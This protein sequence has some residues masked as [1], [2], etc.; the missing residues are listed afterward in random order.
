[1]GCGTAAFIQS[2]WLAAMRVVC[3]CV[4]VAYVPDRHWLTPSWMHDF[5]CTDKYAVLVEQPLYM[6]SCCVR[7]A[8]HTCG[9]LPIGVSYVA[10]MSIGGSTNGC[11]AAWF[12]LLDAL[13]I[14]WYAVWCCH[15]DCMHGTCQGICADR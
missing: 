15:H 9:A 4:Q 3:C 2:S 6:V 8:M 7:R 10:T 5:A 1:V 12:M 14:F 13:G 11:V